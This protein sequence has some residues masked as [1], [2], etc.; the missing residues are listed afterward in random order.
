MKKFLN[1]VNELFF[2]RLNYDGSIYLMYDKKNNNY[3][4]SFINYEKLRNFELI[5]KM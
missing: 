1:A 2:Y 5:I 3:L 4:V